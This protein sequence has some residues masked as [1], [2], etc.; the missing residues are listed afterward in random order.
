MNS[1][2]VCG[3]DRL[4]E[5]PVDFTICP[6]CGTEFGYDDAFITHS[7]LRDKWLRNGAQWWSP[8]DPRPD[9]WDPYLQVDAVVS[10]LWSW[11]RTPPPDQQTSATFA[12]IMNARRPQSRFPIASQ[13]GLVSSM[14]FV[15]KQTSTPQVA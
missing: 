1:C 9:N 3:Y 8:V 2:P 15:P 14:G 4:T 12:N 10:S 7:Q 11:L 6:S 5:P 13:M